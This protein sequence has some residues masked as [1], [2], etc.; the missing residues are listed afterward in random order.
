[1]TNDERNPKSEY[2]SPKEI[3]TTNGSPR[4]ESLNPKE[5]Y[6]SRAACQ[7]T[8]IVRCSDFGFR[9]SFGLRH[10][11]FGFG[12]RDSIRDRGIPVALEKIHDVR[13]HL[14]RILRE[15]DRL[16]SQLFEDRAGNC[17]RERHAIF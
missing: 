4:T 9:D 15:I 5:I 1:M 7:S 11:D 14:R 17:L 2:R 8:A 13:P 16:G 6:A 12:G 3:R 10:S